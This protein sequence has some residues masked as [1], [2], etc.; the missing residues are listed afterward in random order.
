MKNSTIT[1]STHT[2]YG[3]NLSAESAAK[4]YKEVAKAFDLR[5]RPFAV[6]QR[7][8]RAFL[9]WDDTADKSVR[10]ELQNFASMK[11]SEVSTS[12]FTEQA[13]RECF[14]RALRSSSDNDPKRPENVDQED[15]PYSEKQAAAFAEN[16]MVRNAFYEAVAIGASDEKVK[17]VLGALDEIGDE[18]PL[19]SG[20][21]GK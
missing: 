21:Q 15:G 16:L 14:I 2:P 20:W 6:L 11:L 9:K 19:K 17:R 5:R 4:A 13:F 3:G 12:W 10:R 18:E 8:A 1:K 7:I